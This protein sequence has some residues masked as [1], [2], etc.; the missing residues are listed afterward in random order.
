MRRRRGD[1]V[2]QRLAAIVQS[3]EDAIIG[4]DL[5]GVIVSWN[6]SAE[7][8]FG[9]TAEDAIGKP[10]TILIP[11]DRLQEEADILR[12]LR[13]GQHVEHFETVRLRKNG[14]PVEISVAVSPIK[15]SAGE[16]IGA[17]KTARDITERK[18]RDEQIVVLARESVAPL[19]T[20][21]SFRLTANA[22]G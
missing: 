15:N 8:L 20:G 9:Y 13:S 16:V 4:K 2:A 3:S 7:R 5:N 6:G 11:E 18:R 10:I 1:E 21:R 14:A 17:S 22:I 19:D 12:R